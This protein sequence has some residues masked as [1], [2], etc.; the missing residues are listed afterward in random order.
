[1]VELEFPA[2]ETPLSI[3]AAN[4]MHWAAKRRLLD[5]WIEATIWAWKL[6]KGD[7]S[8][9]TGVPCNVQMSLPFNDRRRKDPSNYTGT[10]VKRCVDSLVKF[11]CLVW[12]DDNADWVTIVDSELTVGGPARIRIWPRHPDKTE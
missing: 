8:E 2:P 5:P 6:F 1:L 10:V 3:N 7:K 4:R 12:P 11:P 9:V